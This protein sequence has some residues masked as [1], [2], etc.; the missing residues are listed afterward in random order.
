MNAMT[1]QQWQDY[2]ASL[3]A[4]AES[5]EQAQK[6]AEQQRQEAEIKAAQQLAAQQAEA[7][8]QSKLT[9]ASSAKLSAYE[10]GCV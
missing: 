1:E 9:K 10:Q 5:E 4:Q 8:R 2:N 7:D 3:A 6:A